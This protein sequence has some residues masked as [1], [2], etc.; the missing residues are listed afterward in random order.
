MKPS[1]KIYISIIGLLILGVITI[2][3]FS[4]S[5]N[6]WNNE[7]YHGMIEGIYPNEYYHGFP[8]LKFT[9]GELIQLG[10]KEEMIFNY[11]QIGDSIVKPSGSEIISVFRK[12]RNGNWVEKKFDCSEKSVRM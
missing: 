4:K 10:I 7:E 3:L 6:S 9:N 12:D 8:Q 11:I 1:I 2:T 5:D